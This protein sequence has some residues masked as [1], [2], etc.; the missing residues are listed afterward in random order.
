[1]V[2]RVTKGFVLVAAM[3]VGLAGCSGGNEAGDGQT[4]ENDQAAQGTQAAQ[5]VQGTQPSG[6]TVPYKLGS[7]ERGGQP[8]L[9]LVLDDTQV[10]DI[11]E[12]NAA[13]ESD[14]QSAAALTVPAD[15]IELISQYG[16]GWQ[17]RLAAIAGNVSGAATAPSYVYT[18]DELT[19]L[20]PVRP[21]LILNGGGNYMEHVEGIEEVEGTTGA[22]AEVGVN[23]ESMPGI[24]EREPGDTR[25]NPYLFQKSPTNVIGPNDPIVMPRGRTNIDFECEFALVIGREAKYVPLESAEDYIFGYTAEIDVSDRGGRNDQKMGGGPDWLVGKNHDTFAPLG[26]FITPKAFLP[27]PMNTRQTFT[28]NGEVMQDSN[29]S[30]MTH[31]IYELL[32]YASNILTLHPGTVIAGGS[33]AGTNIEREEPRWMRPGDTAVCTMQG[34]GSQTHQVVAANGS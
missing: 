8:F 25:P 1:M 30:R 22:A 7:F 23:A 4:A 19:V 6:E 11:G 24:W 15:M 17:G 32:H 13:F 10:V 29:T 26:P 34:V 2:A 14:N 21:P 3:A 9:G 5:G 12:A 18:V 33:P 28:L 20:P 31:D 16:A 27:E